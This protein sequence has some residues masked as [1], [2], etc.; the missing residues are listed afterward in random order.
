MESRKGRPQGSR[1]KFGIS[2]KYISRVDAT[3]RILRSATPVLNLKKF[4]QISLLPAI[5]IKIDDDRNPV[6]KNND[7]IEID[8]F[9]TLAGHPV[10]PVG[11]FDTGL[12][13]NEKQLVREFI[14][15]LCSISDNFDF[16]KELA[17]CL[18][19][20]RSA[21]DRIKNQE[22]AWTYYFE[23]KHDGRTKL[24]WIDVNRIRYIPAAGVHWQQ[25]M[26]K[27]NA[28]S[29][30]VWEYLLSELIQLHSTLCLGFNKIPLFEVRNERSAK[31]KLLEIFGKAEM[32][33][34]LFTVREGSDVVNAYRALCILFGLG[35]DTYMQWKQKL[36]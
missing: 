9:H 34:K 13:L 30:A 22:P 19:I 25:Q 15:H 10:L 3:F 29:L 20:A 5:I 6:I 2:K 11:L 24:T 33:E 23:H 16:L 4:E 26:N 18:N 21:I 14:G 32:E 36:K 28:Y 27:I 12:H 8:C 35:A 17:Q 1:N 31:S 7:L